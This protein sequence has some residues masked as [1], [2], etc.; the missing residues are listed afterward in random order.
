MIDLKEI[1]EGL[2]C[3]SNDVTFYLDTLSGEVIPMTEEQ[4]KEADMEG[5]EDDHA[6]EWQR[7][8]RAEAKLIIDNIGNRFLRLPDSFELHNWQI[9]DDFCRSIADPQVSIEFNQAIHGSGA[10]RNFRRCLE[11][12]ELEKPWYSHRR[13]ALR[14][15]A[16]EW[17]RENGVDY[18]D[19]AGPSET[20]HVKTLSPHQRSD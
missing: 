8:L 15:I 18:Q 11:R 16:I 2:E 19:S 13:R 1:V 12:H 6:H 3:V 17:C 14:E 9:M 10:F 5:S 4:R 7:E 20:I